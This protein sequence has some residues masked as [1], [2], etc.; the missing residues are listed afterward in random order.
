M[1]LYL[2]RHGVARERA[3]AAP[4]RDAER[5]LTRR[6]EKRVGQIARALGARG[7]SFD[8]ILSSPL[9]R[10]KETAE[11]VAGVF[12]RGV[13]PVLSRNLR[14]GG[15]P[16]ALLE[17]MATDHHKAASILI[18]GHEPYLSILISVMLSGRRDV[19]LTM[20]KGSVCHLSVSSIR[21]G[22]CA[23]LEWLMPPAQLL[24]GK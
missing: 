4:H 22:R 5:P 3:A 2:M 14:P 18:V 23:T 11:I 8:V 16:A 12:K 6:G 21:Y 15:S 20:K 10:A 19:A 17:E 13:Q 24:A 9:R 1:D 7:V